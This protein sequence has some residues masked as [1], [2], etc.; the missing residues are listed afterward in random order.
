MKTNHFIK[1]VAL[2]LVCCIMFGCGK[3]KNI[4]SIYGTVTD[5]ATGDPVGNANVSLNPRGE[6]TLTGS[7]GTFQFNDIEDGNYSLS[8]SKNGYVDLDDDYVI[9][10]ANGNNVRRDV[11]LKQS[12]VVVTVNGIEIDTLDFGSDVSFNRIYFLVT[13]NTI[14]SIDVDLGSSSNWITIWIPGSNTIIYPNNGKS[15][16]IE[17]KRSLLQVG[18]NIGY[19]YINAGAFSKTLVLKATRI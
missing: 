17:I 3:N 5:Y 13:N 12:R 11:Q 14:T 15:F 16:E 6:T 10:I 19:V 7:D 2:L 8:L 18:N 1:F 9:E 4:G